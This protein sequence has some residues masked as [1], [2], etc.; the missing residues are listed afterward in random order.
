MLLP[1]MDSD[2]LIDAVALSR[3]FARRTALAD[4]SFRASRGE[5]VA[6]LGPNGSGKSTL[7]RLL[8]GVLAPTSGALRVAGHDPEDGRPAMRRRIGWLPENPS[9][10]REMRVLEYLKYRAALKG[11]PARLAATQVRVVVAQCA[12][13]ECARSL[14]GTLS[15][16]SLRRV[17][18]AD[19]LLGEP[20][21][22]LLDE[23]QAGLDHS[24]RAVLAEWISAVAQT[25][26]L[27]LFSSHLLDESSRLASRALVLCDGRLAADLPLQN[28]CL[29][30][31]EPLPAAYPR[32]VAPSRERR[33]P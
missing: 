13:A 14:L 26:R 2:V 1:V 27:V 31:G 11:L 25:R 8:A 10:P 3:R 4:V 33:A 30:T 29:P 21:I 20:D 16:G 22:L 28:G 7:L 23:P 17:G 19:A 5:S 32:L 9:F 6:V 15:R 12:L 24:A 18:I